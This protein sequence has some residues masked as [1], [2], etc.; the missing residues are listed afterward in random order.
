MYSGTYSYKVSPLDLETI[1]Q[2]LCDLRAC[3]LVQSCVFDHLRVVTYDQRFLYIITQGVHTSTSRVHVAQDTRVV[4]AQW[5]VWYMVHDGTIGQTLEDYRGASAWMLCEKIETTAVGAK[6][7]PNG[8]YATARG[9]GEPA[10]ILDVIEMSP[11]GAFMQYHR[12]TYDYLCDVIAHELGHIDHRRVRAWQRTHGY[13]FSLTH[14]GFDA[15]EKLVTSSSFHGPIDPRKVLRQCIN[16]VWEMYA[17]TVD[18]EAKRRFRHKRWQEEHKS[19]TTAR[20]RQL[21]QEG[22]PHSVGTY[23]AHLLIDA[24]PLYSDRMG[25][26]RSITALPTPA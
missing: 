2:G 13:Q 14:E 26:L 15:F 19:M 6:R 9:R 3:R 11:P 18:Q 1:I 16:A 21:V 25:F 12:S 5:K 7:F 22:S 20:K 24:I 10:N 23:L 4:H 17:M 8:H